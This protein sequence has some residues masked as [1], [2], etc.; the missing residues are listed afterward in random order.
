M[1]DVKYFID[2][3]REYKIKHENDDDTFFDEQVGEF[4]PV[5]Y[6][7]DFLGGGWFTLFSKHDRNVDLQNSIEKFG[8]CESEALILLCFLG[9]LSQYFRDDIYVQFGE[10]PEVAKEMNVILD[11]IISKAP[12]H[13]EG[14]LYRFL[15]DYD[16]SDSNVG[17]IIRIEHSLTTTID[18]WR[19]D[20]DSYCITSLPEKM[21]K[22][23]DLYKIYNH[24]NENQVNFER[25]SI[26]KVISIVTNS[27]T[28][29]R[30]IYM[31]EIE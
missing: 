15:N 25:G 29:F 16:K 31:E 23:H 11:S 8:L 20:T 3:E 17:D 28:G 5:R 14:L 13:R 2:K 24:G 18:D 7:D 27:E 12:Q 1:K 19:Q 26:F 6:V 10:V 4:V 9:N 22:A 30:R 21:T